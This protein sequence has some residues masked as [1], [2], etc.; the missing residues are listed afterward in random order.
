VVLLETNEPPGATQVKEIAVVGP[1]ADTVAA[2]VHGEPLQLELTVEV[3]SVI[4]TGCVIVKVRDV[5]QFSAS[6]IFTV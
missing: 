3:T 2:P 5:G 4:D 6:V 1:E